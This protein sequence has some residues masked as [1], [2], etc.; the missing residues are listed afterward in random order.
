VLLAICDNL[1]KFSPWKAGNINN[2]Q[3][4][5]NWIFCFVDAMLRLGDIK[6]G[7]KCCNKQWLMLSGK[8]TCIVDCM[9]H[10]FKFSISI[11]AATVNDKVMRR[12]SFVAYWP[13]VAKSLRIINFVLKCSRK[14]L[15]KHLWKK[16]I[17]T[18]QK[19]L[20]PIRLVVYGN[21]L[22]YCSTLLMH[23]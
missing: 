12:K 17:E 2:W 7:T 20:Y 23:T 21:M 16:F 15:L 10:N 14:L 19:P 8:L 3:R 6:T 13:N 9:H 4:Q 1:W 22:C 18:P 5:L 11:K